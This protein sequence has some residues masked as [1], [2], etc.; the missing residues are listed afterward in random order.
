MRIAVISDLHGNL[1]ATQ[2][3]LADIEALEFKVDVTVCA[4]DVV[5]HS[6]HPNEVIQLLKDNEIETVRG[7]YDE[8]VAGMRSSSG[9]DYSTEREEA[10]DIGAIEWTRENLTAESKKFLT[11]L[12]KES[13]LH[14]SA[15]G[16]TAFK[17][18]KGDER[19][20]EYRKTFVLSALF[21]GLA[22]SSGRPRIN[23]RRVLLVHGSPRDTV[24]YLYPATAQSV[25]R[26]V[27]QDAQAEVILF[28]HTHQGYQ[29]VVDGVAFINVPSVGRPR[30]G[31]PAEY[32]V[33]EIAGP[34]IEV[35]Y[36]TV[37]YD[38]ESEVR[39]IGFTNLPRDLGEYLRSG[40]T[41]T[42]V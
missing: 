8:V 4:G 12:P 38:I 17:G 40:D 14:V 2:A 6:A 37:E 5:G 7:N 29:Q 26:A 30:A 1:A 41:A 19:I 25:L 28:G 27:C 18:S 35:E 42:S 3:V 39:D 22:S 23:A 9:A 32:A 24:E 20:S 34:E 33:V 13:R 15:S 11:D 21:G 36:R 16:R 31:G 10:I